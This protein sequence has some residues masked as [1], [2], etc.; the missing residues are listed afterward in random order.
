[1]EQDQNRVAPEQNQNLFLV[2]QKRDRPSLTAVA[3]HLG[4]TTTFFFW[5]AFFSK[6]T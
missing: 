3:L 5:E 4:Q 2:L 6:A 1:M